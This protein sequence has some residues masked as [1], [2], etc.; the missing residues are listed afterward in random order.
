[1]IECI[2]QHGAGQGVEIFRLEVSADGICGYGR[3][4]GFCCAWRDTST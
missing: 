1:L 2:A 4:F 3:K